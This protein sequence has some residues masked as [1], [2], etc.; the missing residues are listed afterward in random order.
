VTVAD[1][2]NSLLGEQLK[3]EVVRKGSRRCAS[4]SPYVAQRESQEVVVHLSR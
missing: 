4:P 2:F 3:A 1:H